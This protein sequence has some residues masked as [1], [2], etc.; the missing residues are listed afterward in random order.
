MRIKNHKA[1]A[2]RFEA[3]AVSFQ[4]FMHILPMHGGFQHLKDFSLVTLGVA[5]KRLLPG[6]GFDGGGLG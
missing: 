3:Q 1:V 6:L 4:R 5:L 2:V